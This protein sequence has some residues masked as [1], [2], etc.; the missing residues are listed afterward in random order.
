MNGLVLLL[1]GPILERWVGASWA[2]TIFTSSAVVGSLVSSIVNPPNIIGVGAS[3]G[4]LGLVAAAAIVSLRLP[5][6]LDRSRLIR[7]SVIT[8]LASLLPGGSGQVGGTLVDYAAHV[9]G[10]LA[11]AL[12]CV[13]LL[14]MW[15]RPAVRR[16]RLVL[17][18]A[19]PSFFFATA[20]LSV[21]SVSEWRASFELVDPTWPSSAEW[22]TQVEEKVA[23]FPRDPR[24]QYLYAA[25]LLQNGHRDQA[26]TH[27]RLA[28]DESVLLDR[29]F[30]P[31]MRQMIVVTQAM[32]LSNEGHR[33]DAMA[34]V[35]SICAAAT[36][37]GVRAMLDGSRL[38]QPRHPS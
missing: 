27:L 16:G 36:D 18:V 35:L 2:A 3:G 7:R 25:H 19:V 26:K 20:L 13:A 29:Y 8:L 1:I 5:S 14:W 34:M 37:A 32:V 23:Q 11:G 9:G 6:G 17:E 4:L 33:E 24:I 38:C 22:H 28:L 10:T 12:V 15:S 21:F 31:E 30:G